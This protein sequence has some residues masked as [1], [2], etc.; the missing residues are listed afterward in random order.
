MKRF[1]KSSREPP[2]KS[3]LGWVFLQTERKEA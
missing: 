1:L 2:A 3:S